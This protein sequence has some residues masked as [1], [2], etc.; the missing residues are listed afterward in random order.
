MTEGNTNGA[1]DRAKRLQPDF[2]TVLD[3][4]FTQL[5]T[6]PTFPVPGL[7][8]LARRGSD[9][10][11]RAFGVSDLET[12]APMRTDA[13]FRMYSMTKVLT[14]FVALRLYE[15][16][17]LAFDDPVSDYIPSFGRTWNI[18]VDSEDGPDRIDYCSFLSGKTATYDYRLIPAREPIRIKHLMSETSGIEYDLFSEYEVLFGGGISGR[19]NGIVANALR[20]NIHPDVYRST[21][22]LGADLTLAQFVDT[23]AAAGVLTCEPGEFSYGHGATVLGR[24]LEVVY[25]RQHG[26]FK[27]FAE[28]MHELLFQPLGMRNAVFHLHDEDPRQK[29]IPTLYGAMLEADGQTVRIAREEN[30]LPSTGQPITNQTAHSQGPR[31]YDSGDTGSL[32][33]ASD[34]ARFYDMLLAEG[35]APSGERLLSAQGVRTLCKGRFT[36]LRLDVPLARAFGVA[37]DASPFARSFNFGWATAHGDTHHSTGYA[38]SDHYDMC[39]WGGYAATQGFFYLNEDAYMLVCPQ[40][41][42]TTVG[43]FLHAQPLIRDASMAAFHRT[44]R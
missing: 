1:R 17:L 5:V 43:G 26:V 23:I 30:C 24:V 32:M 3:A 11:H 4:H 12:R 27:R 15:D 19:T 36:G 37:G 16:G 21:A 22:I 29:L 35:V 40:M 33:T 14:S 13:M 44:W 25:E 20:Q 42:L 41:M 6:S 28:I 39:H 2:E 38:P 31:T 8:V 9:I 7:V 10:Y 18:A 34:Y